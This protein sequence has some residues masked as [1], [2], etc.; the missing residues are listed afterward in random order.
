VFNVITGDAETIGSQLMKSPLVRK[1]TFT[2]S[3]EVGKILI[4]QSADT[5]KKL[6]LELGGNAPFVVFND[7]NIDQAVEGAIYGKYRN[8][9]QTCICVNRFLVHEKIA[10]EFTERFIIRS[11]ELVVGDGATPTTQ[12][13]PLITDEA[14][15]KVT[16]LIMSARCEGAS[17]ALAPVESSRGKRFISP[18]VITGVRPF[19]SIWNEER[20]SDQSAPSRPSQQMMKLS[21]SRIAHRTDSPHTCTRATS[22][23]R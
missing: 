10:Q 19:M 21:L 23:A 11:K 2:G 18:T 20:S 6:T 17:I 3:T 15:E 8:A 1:V 5:V 4:R 13:G 14:A 16:R 12:V 9:G 22:P 7:A